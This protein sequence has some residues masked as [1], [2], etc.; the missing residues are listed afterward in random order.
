MSIVFQKDWKDENGRLRAIPHMSTKNTSFLRTAQL[1]RRMGISNYAFPLCLYDPDLLHVDVHDLEE[2]TPENEILRTKV[3]IEARK[4]VWYYLRE[5]IRIY[6]QGG[7]PVPFRL[8]RGSCAMVWCFSN[9]IDYTGM[10]PRQTGKLQDLDSLIRT[11]SGWVRMGDI[12]LEQLIVTPDGGTT[13]VKGI[14]PQGEV[15]IYRIYFEDGRW[16]DC[17]LE[18]LWKVYWPHWGEED[19]GKWR[20]LTLSQILEHMKSHTKSNNRLSIQLIEPEIK[21]DINLPIDPYLLGAFLGDGNLS[22]SQLRFT[23]ADTWMVDEIN[24]LLPDE[25]ELTHSSKYDYNV[26]RKNRNYGKPTSSKFLQAFKDLNIKGCRSWEKFIPNQYMNASSNQRLALLQGLMDTDGSV[27]TPRL[28]KD[29]VTQKHGQI[30]YCTTSLQLAYQIQELVRSLGGMCKLSERYTHYTYK[31]EK[32]KGRLSY[33]LYIRLKDRSSAFRIPRKKELTQIGDYK[34]QDSL[35]LGIRSVEFIKRAEAQCIEVDHPDHLYITD[36]YVVTHNTVTALS[37][38]SWVIY[39]SG[40]EFSVGHLAKDNSLRQENVK[41][42]KSFGENLPAWWVVEDRHKDKK[43]AEEIYYSALKT[44]YVTFVGQ[45]EKSAAD[46]QARGASPPVFHFDEFEYINNIGISYPTILASTGTAREN[47]RRNGRP[48]SNIITTTAGDPTKPE[49]QEAAKILDGAMPFTERLYDIENSEIL[50]QIVK[51]ASPQKMIIGVFSHLQLGYDNNWLREKIAR[52]RMTPDQVLRD[53]LN[54]RVS[55]QDNPVIPKDVLTLINSSEREPSY[56]QILSNKFVIYWY[57]PK[58]VVH[59]Q[60]FKER[61]IVLGCDSSEMIGRDSTTL[62]GTDP[63]SLETVCSF[64]CSE[65]NINVVGVMIAQLLLMFP[66]MILVPENKSSGTAII[67]NV[68]LILRKEGHNPFY[69][70]F[71]WVV[72]NCHED[73]F[74]KINT[75]DHSLLDTAVKRH[76]GIKT[77]KSKREELYSSILLEACVKAASRIKDK[78]LIQELG[79]LT[80]RNGRVDHAVGG[81]DDT[82]VA[83][84]MAMW[85]I[86]NGKHLDMYGIKPGTV[87]SHINPGQPDKTALSVDRQM[88][89]RNKIEDLE[90]AIKQQHDPSARKLLE[91]DLTLFKSM[92]V[93]GPIPIPTTADE[94]NRDPRRFTDS[95]I[96]EQSRNPVKSEEVERSLR[97]LLRL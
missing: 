48:H 44:H 1:L 57:L 32:L 94:L 88:I 72:N 22:T 61:S 39:S 40:L 89:I 85:F 4:N 50:H 59:S 26:V 65:G 55:I 14:Y 19:G 78:I 69:R 35:K 9:G 58:E 76:F 92:I 10:Q 24:R 83:W 56:I 77:D 97:M 51:A 71:N 6:E 7:N 2:N 42:V 63:R 23:T 86:L 45:S 38:T 91:A 33:R 75:R 93:N 36:N 16:A 37:L 41:R 82:V 53:Y 64:R 34:Y 67:D 68:S 60:A 90:K 74:S 3:Q 18:H 46:K 28:C 62:I 66:K 96:A 21:E 30:E 43:N 15:D 84:L 80:V 8:D 54:R 52:N 13:N 95:D 87:L 20:V 47:A 73:P 12:K 27:E 5:C 29:G 11:P 70:M 25:V 81:H 17:G 31:N 79:S 49:C